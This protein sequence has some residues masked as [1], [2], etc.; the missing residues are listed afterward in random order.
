[1]NWLWLIGAIIV[2]LASAACIIGTLYE[3][4]AGKAK[5]KGANF[6]GGVAFHAVTAVAA[7]WMFLRAIR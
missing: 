4:S 5:A 6:W 3:L 2:W 1:M 7:L